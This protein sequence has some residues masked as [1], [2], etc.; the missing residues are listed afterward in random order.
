MPNIVVGGN[1]K[2][3]AVSLPAQVYDRIQA[4]ADANKVTVNSFLVGAI[5]GAAGY[6]IKVIEEEV[7]S[8]R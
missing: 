7:S 8:V 2:E 5:M 6:K 1:T 3:L 4:I